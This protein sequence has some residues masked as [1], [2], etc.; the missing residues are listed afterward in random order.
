VQ[1]AVAGISQ[2]TE[3]ANQINKQLKAAVDKI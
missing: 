1:L 3:H 2:L